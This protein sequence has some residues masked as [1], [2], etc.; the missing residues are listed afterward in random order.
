L[1][2]RFPGGGLP[3][4]KSGPHPF[5]HGWSTPIVHV[6]ILSLTVDGQTPASAAPPEPPSAP[7]VPPPELDPELLPTPPDPDPLEDE[8]PLLLGVP[9]L[10]RLP[11]LEPL[12][13]P[14]PPP[15]LEPAPLLA[16]PLLEP[17][18]GLPV[19]D[20]LFLSLQAAAIAP[21]ASSAPHANNDIE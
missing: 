14:E 2:P 15:L 13:L 12:P 17:L 20:G 18:L 19:I 3:V 16:P 21:I 4:G 8:P 10:D 11:L 9:L 5:E 1:V 6:V 7:T